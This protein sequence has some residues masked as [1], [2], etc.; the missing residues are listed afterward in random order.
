MINPNDTGRLRDILENWRMNPGA[1]PNGSGT[2]GLNHNDS[3]GWDRLLED[4]RW[5]LNALRE[6]NGDEPMQVRAFQHQAEGPGF[7]ELYQR[8]PGMFDMKD[9]NGN[10]HYQAKNLYE[11]NALNQLRGLK[12]F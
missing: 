6:Q 11:H 3:H 1:A 4:Q 8:R 5:A 9:G 10:Y 12:G 2:T 7:A